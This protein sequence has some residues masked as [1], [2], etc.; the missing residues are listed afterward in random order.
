MAPKQVVIGENDKPHA[1]Q[2]DLG[3]SIVGCSTPCLDSL[4]TTSLCHRVTVKELPPITPAN[5][6]RILESDFKDSG[7]DSKTVSQD[8]IIFLN[9][10]NKVIHE[11]S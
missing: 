11:N 1:I 9:M 7:V 6:I 8:D 10:M 3:W 5:A 2:T 4:S